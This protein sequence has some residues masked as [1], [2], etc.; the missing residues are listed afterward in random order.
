[1]FPKPAPSR[2]WAFLLG[3]SAL[4]WAN[5]PYL[6][7]Y[8]VADQQ[9]FFSGFFI[10]ERDGF[11]YLAK[12][13]QGAEGSWL[14][15]LPFTTEPHQGAILYSFYIA[16]GKAARSLGVSM[17]AACHLGT[18]REPQHCWQAARSSCTASPRPHAGEG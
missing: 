9:T 15:H 8:L 16:L 7:G 1:M 18:W 3:M 2:V 4:C 14:F 10:F 17:A 13:R 11:S 6:V 5:L 12:V